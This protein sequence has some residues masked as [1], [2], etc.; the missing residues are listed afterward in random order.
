MFRTN[1]FWPVP[2]TKRMVKF[3]ELIFSYNTTKCLSIN[4]R[5]STPMYA[6]HRFDPFL[7]LTIFLTSPILF[8]GITAHKQ[9][10]QAF[11]IHWLEILF[12]IFTFCKNLFCGSHNKMVQIYIIISFSLCF[13]KLGCLVFIVSHCIRLLGNL[14]VFRSCRK[15]LSF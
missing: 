15:R 1:T 4:K 5:I 10:Q 14:L 7:Y 6:Q 3:D 2:K 8:H 13:G 9:F 11:C 12:N